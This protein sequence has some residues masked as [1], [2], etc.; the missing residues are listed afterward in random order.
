MN[1]SFIETTSVSWFGRIKRSVGG[2][3]I[4]VLLIV[5]MVFLLFWNEGRAV[6][7]AKSL[8]EG[9]AAV[10]SVSADAVDPANEGKLVH[11]SGPVTTTA[12]PTDGDFGISQES[13]RLVRTAEMYQWKESSKSETKTKIGGGE[14]TVTTYS[15]SK[16]W[17]DDAI[18]SS[19][20]KQPSGHANPSMEITSRSF[21]IP[22]GK[23]G[24]FTLHTPVIDKIYGGDNLP[25]PADQ[26]DKIDAAY[27]GNQRVSVVDGRIFLGFNPTAPVIGDYRISYEYVPIGIIS[28]IGQQIG[29][30]FSPYQTIAGDQLLMVDTGNV[31]AD[32]MFADAISTNIMITW[33]LRL[34][35][36]V[37]LILGF[38]ML[39][40][41]IAVLADF[42]PFLGS[43]V[44]MG[45]GLIALLLGI[46]VGATTIAVA[47]FFYRPVLAIG[48][49][50]VGALIAAGIIYLGRR[51]RAAVVAPAQ[52]ATPPPA[53]PPPAGGT[54]TAS[55]W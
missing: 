5:G 49:F 51:R 47:W 41:P 39:L 27:G 8:A 7:T 44:R 54:M 2:V 29:A 38:S 12:M 37:L 53:A 26:V 55:K 9:S 14:E 34:V 25:V 33:I 28:V 13:V 50:A 10:V 18:D 32:K 15:Y 3:V 4:G 31:P 22:D 43:M 17:D 23:L 36:L 11:V 6:Q 1:D 21:Q 40:A 35:G 46:F 48:I 19:S 16:E 24:A 42:L 45:T 30:L 52:S 20:F